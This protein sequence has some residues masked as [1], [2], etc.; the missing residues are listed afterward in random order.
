[1]VSQSVGAKKLG[2][3]TVPIRREDVLGMDPRTIQELMEERLVRQE[4]SLDGA[5]AAAELVISK[6]VDEGSLDDDDAKD[7]VRSARQ[8]KRVI[9]RLIGPDNTST[10]SARQPRPP[11]IPA[12]ATPAEPRPAANHSNPLPAPVPRPSTARQVQPE[13]DLTQRLRQ[14]GMQS[15]TP[16]AAVTG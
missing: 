8:F 1:L 15:T 6:Q 3:S 5:L 10:P 9:E 12:P 4:M 2:D 11:P 13:F 16:H 7:L 14:W